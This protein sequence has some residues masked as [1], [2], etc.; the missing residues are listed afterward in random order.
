MIR[1]ISFVLEVLIATPYLSFQQMLR[2]IFFSVSV[3]KKIDLSLRWGDE[4]KSN[5][6]PLHKAFGIIYIFLIGIYSPVTLVAAPHPPELSYQLNEGNNLNAFLRDGKIAAHVLLRSG[7]NPRIIAA[8][9]AGNSGVGIWFNNLAKV[10][11]WTLQTE[12]QPIMLFDA[13][14]RPLYGVSFRASINAPQLVVKQAVLSNVRFLRD[15][16]AIQKFPNEV[17]ASPSIAGQTLEF[18]RDRLDGAPGYQ[19]TIHIRRGHTLKNAIVAGPDGIIEMD[20]LAASGEVPLTPLLLTDLLN[21]KAA[22][23]PAAR[24]ALNFLSYREK[25]LAGSWRFNTYFGRDTLMSVRLLM[26]VL[27][28]SAIEAGLSAVLARLS[29]IGEVSHEEGLAE[30]AL[31]EHKH[32]GSAAGDAATLDYGMVDSSFMLAP[33]A[34]NYL[35]NHTDGRGRAARYLATALQNENATRSNTTTGASLVANMRLVISQ[36]TPFFNQP[37]ATTLVPIKPGRMS[38]EWRDSD[39]GL[40]RGRFAYDVNAVFIP[41]ALLAIDK[42]L[43]SGMLDPYLS[44]TDR[45]MFAKASK[46]ATIW[47]ERAP[48]LFRISISVADA[49]THIKNYSTALHINPDVAI[50]SLGNQSL[51]F[52]ALSLDVDGNPVPI[53]HSDEGFALLFSN[54]SPDEV[55]TFITAIMRPFPAGL[56][57][58]VGLLVA[59]PAFTDSAAQTRFSKTAY[60][61]TVI[62]SWQQALLAAGL[63]NQLKRT[64]MSN[65]VRAH[66]IAAQSVLWRAIK[67]TKSVQSSELWS[68][69]HLNNHYAVAPFG[70]GNGDVDESNAAQLWSTVY[71]SVQP[72]H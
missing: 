26:P 54:L 5:N 64:D 52:H 13:K 66:L 30:F 34:A 22:D 6:K 37:N 44:P 40:G 45:T 60:H 55:D 43:A 57:T 48:P 42:M 14:Q 59:N 12:P 62:W 71:L 9:P 67:A 27:Q 33:V 15:Y 65:V 2:S 4:P 11:T 39:E 29:P 18:R 47:L 51:V 35:L 31:V 32:T 21:D 7:L 8:F 38:G 25:F 72:P 41:A 1:C 50:T 56:M 10:A 61:G 24:M 49:R 63:E 23:D 53:M 46:M 19:L 16:E 17:A 68:W 58:D 36:A 28:P 69:T 70:A 3:L 20:I